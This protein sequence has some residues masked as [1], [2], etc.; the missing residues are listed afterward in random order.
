MPYDFEV[1]VAFRGNLEKHCDFPLC[2]ISG[3]IFSKSREKHESVFIV[4]Y[5]LWSDHRDNDVKC[6]NINI[7][8]S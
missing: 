1:D 2:L 7:Q 6:L 5:F 8:Q 4:F 3:C